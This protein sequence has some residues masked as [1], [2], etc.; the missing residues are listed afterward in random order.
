M[1]LHFSFHNDMEIVDQ[2]LC[3]TLFARDAVA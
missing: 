1:R 2:V 3:V